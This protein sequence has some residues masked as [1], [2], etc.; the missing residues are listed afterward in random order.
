MIGEIPKDIYQKIHF[1]VPIA[2]IDVVIVKN[3]K[4]LL[5]KRTNKP[6][7]GEFWLPGGRVYKGETLAEAVSRKTLQET[8]LQTQKIKKIGIDET[9]FEDGPFGSSTHTINVIY[10]V[11]TKKGE[12]INDLQHDEYLWADLKTK[13]LHPY[14][15]KYMK[16][17]LNNLYG[18]IS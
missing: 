15:R 17:V 3:N 16:I 7:Q 4:I 2:C 18:K 1:S 12:V 6:A 11:T 14:V 5:C 10:L 13:N 9:M 8:D